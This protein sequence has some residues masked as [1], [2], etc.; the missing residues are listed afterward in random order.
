MRVKKFFAYG[1]AICAAAMTLS[2]LPAGYG[3]QFEFKM[4]DTTENKSTPIMDK[5]SL[6]F[7]K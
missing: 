6:H 4:S 1:S 5:V 3:F 7:A 2:T